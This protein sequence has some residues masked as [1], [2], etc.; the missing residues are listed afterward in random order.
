MLELRYL[1]TTVHKFPILNVREFVRWLKHKLQT[2]QAGCGWKKSHGNINTSN[3]EKAFQI[4]HA[5]E[6]QP[7]ESKASRSIGSICRKLLIGVRN[8]IFLVENES[9]VLLT[10]KENLEEIRM[11]L[12]GSV[13]TYKIILLVSQQTD[14]RKRKTNLKSH[15]IPSTKKK[16]PFTKSFGE[17]RYIKEKE[18][19]MLEGNTRISVRWRKS[20]S[21]IIQTVWFIEQIKGSYKNV[22]ALDERDVNLMLKGIMLK[23][24]AF[25]EFIWWSKWLARPITL[26]RLM[27]YS[28][29]ESI[30]PNT[31]QREMPLN[32]SKHLHLLRNKHL[33]WFSVQG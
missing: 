26:A 17:R 20:S 11:S 5:L 30:Y 27:I 31:I 1:I 32:N 29:Y 23:D 14:H 21:F 9:E 19:K 13:K 8:P 3:L 24:T 15:Q 2:R 7:K 16:K 33:L 25:S 18:S 6:E 10:V 12:K 4:R 28:S 22:L